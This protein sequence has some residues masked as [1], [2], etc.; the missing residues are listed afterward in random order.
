MNQPHFLII[1]TGYNC[2]AYVKACVDSVKAQTY[3]N[4]KAVFI[5][6]CSSDA[7]L[8]SIIT[9][10]GFERNYNFAYDK[11]H[12]NL[13]TIKCRERVIK[14]LSDF[15]KYE[16]PIIVWLD[17]DDEL[18][19][20]ALEKLAE[21]YRDPNIWLTY[22]NY[23]DAQGRIFFDEKTIEYSPEVH[24]ARSYRQADW[25]FIHLRSYRIQLYERLTQE[26]LYPAQRKIYPDMNMLYCLLEMA[27]PEH[28]KAIPDVLYKYNHNTPLSV[29]NRFSDEERNAEQA[30]VKALPKA[31]AVL[32]L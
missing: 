18:M 20:N 32:S 28:I 14:C 8:T 9:H 26:M 12:E 29:I 4:F 23:I 7:T 24:A 5:D 3:K 2:E 27:G 31:Q 16:N 10:A 15:Y 6:D 22:G 11:S 17:L 25:R 19:P 13:G 21:V 30:F 1:A